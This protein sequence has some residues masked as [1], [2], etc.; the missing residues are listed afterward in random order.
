MV[1][2]ARSFQQTVVRNLST[3]NE[4]GHGLINHGV[5]RLINDRSVQTPLHDPVC[6]RTSSL[7]QLA[8]D[9]A[10][11]I[12]EHSESK[13]VPEKVCRNFFSGRIDNACFIARSPFIGNHSSGYIRNTDPAELVELPEALTIPGRKVIIGCNYM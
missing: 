2:G 3:N 10:P 8:D 13:P 9:T 11:R 1:R 5:I 12:S 7:Q 4:R 6:R